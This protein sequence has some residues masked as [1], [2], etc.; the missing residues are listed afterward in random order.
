MEDTTCLSN[1][2]RGGGQAG[3]PG[4]E[5]RQASCDPGGGGVSTNREHQAVQ[6]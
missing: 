1:I 3:G 2:P 4:V 5:G 6:F